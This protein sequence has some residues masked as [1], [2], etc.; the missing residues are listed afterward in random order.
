MDLELKHRKPNKVIGLGKGIQYF[1]ENAINIGRASGMR[2]C[3][4]CVSI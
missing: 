1:P 3:S 4:V 2:G